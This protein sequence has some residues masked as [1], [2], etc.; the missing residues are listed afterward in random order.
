MNINHCQ[1]SD[2]TMAYENDMVEKKGGDYYFKGTLIGLCL[3]ISGKE[4]LIVENADGVCHIFS[5]AQLSSY[6]KIQ[7][8]VDSHICNT[9]DYRGYSK[10]SAEQ[11]PSLD[12]DHQE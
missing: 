10:E 9:M 3:K 11:G 8:P 5:P 12:L 4:R 1:I 7:T 6:K 2:G